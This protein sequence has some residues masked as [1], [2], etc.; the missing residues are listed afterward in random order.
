MPAS[1]KNRRREFAIDEFAI[2]EVSID[3]EGSIDIDELTHVED[4]QAQSRQ[5]IAPDIIECGL[6]FRVDGRA[7]ERQVPCGVYRNFQIVTRRLL[8]AGGELVRL[9]PGEFA[10]HELEGLRRHR[11]ASPEPAATR[12]V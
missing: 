6:T 1:C 8:N 2:D 3:V 12:S 11:R 4:Q 10:I 5:R 9:R 7:A